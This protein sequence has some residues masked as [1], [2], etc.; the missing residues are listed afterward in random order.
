VRS[1]GRPTAQAAALLET[2]ILDHATEAFLRDGYAA[3]S[4]ESI[5]RTA[6][7]AKRTIYARWDGKAALF[8]AVVRR[9]ID[10]WLSTAGAW[11]ETADLE[12][13][14]LVA[15]RSILSVALSSEAI[16]LHRLMIAEGGRFPELRTIVARAG[17]DEGVRRIAGLLGKGIAAGQLRTID[18]AFAA[19]QFLGPGRT[20]ASSPWCQRGPDAG[21]NRSLVPG[22]GAAVPVRLSCS[23]ALSRWPKWP[24]SLALP[25]FS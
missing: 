9:L 16:A 10:N 14:L 8:L 18:V 5:A 3:T 1:G 19:E 15:A 24:R 17:A 2:T 23:G 20:A 22:C 4:I 25:D 12:A 11:P 21:G 7:V 13:S 6:R